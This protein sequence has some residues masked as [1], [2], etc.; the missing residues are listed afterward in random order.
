MYVLYATMASKE[1]YKLGM[2]DMGRFQQLCLDTIELSLRL[3]PP[4]HIV[5]P[6]TLNHEAYMVMPHEAEYMIEN[7]TPLP[8]QSMG[9]AEFMR[10]HGDVEKLNLQAHQSAKQKSDNFVVESLLTFKKLPVLIYN[11]LANE[12]WKEKVFPTLAD[13][14]DAACMRTYFVVH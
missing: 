5:I 3:K 1:Q 7:L 8:L 6:E 11:L 4:S 12:L 2:V 13:Y 10:L 9:S 14:G